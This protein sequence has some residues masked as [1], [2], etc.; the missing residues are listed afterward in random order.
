[1]KL[2]KIITLIFSAITFLSAGIANSEP[3][4]ISVGV[5]QSIDLKSGILTVATSGKGDPIK[6][7]D[8][9]YIRVD[10]KVVLLRA[11]F[12]MMTTSKCKPEGKNRK[13]FHKAEKNMEV[14]RFKRGVEDSQSIAKDAERI[15]SHNKIYKVG[16]RGPGG[17]WIFYDKGDSDDGWR[18]LEAAPVDQ[19]EGIQWFNGV[20]LETGAT[21]KAIG[22]GKSNT[23]RIINIQGKGKY[24]AS[25][26]ADYNG[27]SKRDW[28]LPSKNELEM[29]FDFFIRSGMENF[30]RNYYYWSS[31]ESR[32][33]YASYQGINYSNPA[34]AKYINNRVRAIRAF[35]N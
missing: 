2:F 26:C 12:P 31:T 4:G 17:G 3:E 1:M 20:S 13:L 30:Q 19:S 29:M 14:F 16:D 33:G 18:Y 15:D 11:T 35:D 24:A 23:Q 10:D 8:L 27:G 28:F 5:V 32:V 7:G 22:R 21:D 6:M 34:G 25:I 9:L